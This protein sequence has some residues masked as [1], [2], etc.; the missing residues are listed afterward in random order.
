ML[1][2]DAEPA[3]PPA[4]VAPQADEDAALLPDDLRVVID[5]T[6]AQ[7]V[8]I[9]GGVVVLTLLF[10]L[11]AVNGPS[12]TTLSTERLGGYVALGTAC[13][14]LCWLGHHFLMKYRKEFY[15]ADGGIV[16]KV[17]H[18][19]DLEPRV[20]HIPWAEIEDYAVSVDGEKAH[21]RVASVHGYT[22]TLHERRPRPATR[23]LIRRFVKQAE[24]YP[25]AV[26]SPD[27]AGASRPPRVRGEGQ[28][29]FTLIACV[30]WFAMLLLVSAVETVL[31]L[32]LT[33]E[34]IGLAVIGVIGVGVAT[35]L[36]LE[37]PAVAAKDAGSEALTAELRR[38]LRRV[39][40]IRVS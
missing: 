38:W 40:R 15:L 12:A 36:D 35:W 27:D 8:P 29:E 30:G 37:D 21:L 10:G 3:L 13:A 20:F 33:Q 1:A 14:V 26:R 31:D 34:M 2:G 24:R 16:M 6:T 9:V 28:P 39:L 7:P 4:A 17:W 19:T 25:R 23:E 22:A 11:E 32:S 5:G 18:P